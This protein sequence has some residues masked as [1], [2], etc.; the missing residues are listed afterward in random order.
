MILLDANENPFETMVNRYPDPLQTEVKKAIS[1]VK[2]VEIDQSGFF[3][4]RI[5]KLYK[6]IGS[7]STGFAVV[8]G[9]VSIYLNKN[10]KIS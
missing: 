3:I 1:A 7:I 2:N 10:R 5:N 8:L 9:I 6:I 4:L